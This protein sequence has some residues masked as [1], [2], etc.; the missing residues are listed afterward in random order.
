M[1]DVWTIMEQERILH[2]WEGKTWEFVQS[3]FGRLDR[4]L[5]KF[6]MWYGSQFSAIG[7][8]LLGYHLDLDKTTHAELEAGEKRLKEMYERRCRLGGILSRRYGLI[9]N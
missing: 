4:I 1:K 7:H 2:P 6:R 8:G 5:L 3:E 9:I